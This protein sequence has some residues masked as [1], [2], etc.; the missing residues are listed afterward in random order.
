[1][2]PH[3]LQPGAGNCVVVVVVAELVVVV[4][5]AMVDVGAVVERDV[6]GR[7]CDS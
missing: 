6:T 3:G 5:G 1:M 7:H 2:P 4:M